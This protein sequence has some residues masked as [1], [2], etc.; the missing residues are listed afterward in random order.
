MHGGWY[1]V[2]LYAG[3]ELNAGVFPPWFS[4]SPETDSPR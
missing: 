3:W 2:E 1:Q 4:H